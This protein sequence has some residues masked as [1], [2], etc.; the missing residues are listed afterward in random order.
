MIL[1]HKAQL[2]VGRHRAVQASQ[3]AADVRSYHRRVFA[4]WGA[5]VDRSNRSRDNGISYLL[6]DEIDAPAAGC[7][8]ATFNLHVVTQLGWPGA[9]AMHSTCR[10]CYHARPYVEMWQLHV[11]I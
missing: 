2:L 3:V 6:W 10:N 9:I 4:N 1:S 8:Q 5:V 7:A 11:C